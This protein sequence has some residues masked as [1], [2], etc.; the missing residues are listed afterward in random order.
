[1]RQFRWSQTAN[2]GVLPNPAMPNTFLADAFDLGDPW[3]S[4]ICALSGTFNGGPYSGTSCCLDASHANGA[5]CV[6][7][8]RGKWSLNDTRDWANLGT[9]HPRTTAPGGRC[10]VVCDGV[11]VCGVWCVVHGGVCTVACTVLLPTNPNTYFVSF[12]LSSSPSSSGT[13]HPRL[14]RPVGERLSRG[15]F[16]LAY[17]GTSI[18]TGP[19]L[20]GCSFTKE[21]G[22]GGVGGGGSKGSKTGGK[23]GTTTKTGGSTLTLIFNASLL[24][25]ETVSFDATHT[26]GREDT[27][28][29]VLVNASV[30]VMGE[31]FVNRIVANHHPAGN[32]D[33]TFPYVEESCVTQHHITPGTRYTPL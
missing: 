19:T 11:M 2:Y 28:L 12:F 6:G 23:G 33:G 16:S 9:L 15:L 29:Y 20:A 18:A 24:R 5:Q 26:I 32:P 27:A 1:M 8:H 7:D 3:H 22:A 4:P 21:G 17:G 14:K 10:G 13:L 30:D 31:A 25:G